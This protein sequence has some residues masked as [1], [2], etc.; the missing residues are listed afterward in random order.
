[1]SIDTGIGMRQHPSIRRQL[2]TFP[3]REMEHQHNCT[4]TLLTPSFLPTREGY[5]G[6]WNADISWDSNRLYLC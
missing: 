5:I 1:M 3:S 4:D 2:S 6:H